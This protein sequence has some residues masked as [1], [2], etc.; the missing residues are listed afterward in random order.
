MKFF[1]YSGAVLEYS[2][3]AQ[4]MALFMKKWKSLKYTFY[5]EGQKI[6]VEA[7]NNKVYLELIEGNTPV[8]L[9]IWQN[10]YT[11]IDKLEINR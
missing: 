7:F 2:L 5:W 3:S 8:N 1:T 10:K 11:L 6:K 4:P 9:E